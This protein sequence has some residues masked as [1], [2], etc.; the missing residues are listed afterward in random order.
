MEKEKYYIIMADIIG[1]GK[2]NAYELMRDFNDVIN[3]INTENKER[4]LSPLTITLGD[5]FQGISSS[6][7]DAI[8]LMI[9]IEE[10]I[11]HLQKNLKLR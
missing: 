9:K 6:I 10:K 3:S 7:Q 2:H 4:L 5:E 1:S 11:I 8:V